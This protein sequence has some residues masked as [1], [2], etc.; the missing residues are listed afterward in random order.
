MRNRLVPRLFLALAVMS[1][2]TGL[3]AQIADNATAHAV[4]HA[5]YSDWPEKITGEYFSPLEIVTLSQPGVRHRCRASAITTDSLTCGRGRKAVVYQRS[6]VAAIIAPPTHSD[7]HAVISFYAVSAASLAG[8]FFV[9]IEA[10]AITLR[11]VSGYSFLVPA[12][13]T[14][15]FDH[16]DDVLLYQRVDTSLSVTLRQTAKR[17]K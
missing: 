3:S 10:V 4:V 8:S 14:G 7:R 6:D 12:W 1:A 15:P 9:P 5:K 11:V 16:N 13:D 17:H 2:S